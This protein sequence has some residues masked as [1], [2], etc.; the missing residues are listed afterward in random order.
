VLGDMVKT[1]NLGSDEANLT[2]HMDRI[3]NRSTL[4][5]S[6]ASSPNARLTILRGALG[7]IDLHVLFDTLAEMVDQ[8]ALAQG[9]DLPPVGALPGTKFWNYFKFVD[10]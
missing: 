9:L 5:Q 10:N 8:G 3:F 1:R 2:F 7:G 6:F 4:T